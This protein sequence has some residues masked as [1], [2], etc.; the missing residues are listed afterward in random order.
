MGDS[1]PEAQDQNKQK[2]SEGTQILIKYIPEYSM[3]PIIKLQSVQTKDSP[4]IFVLP[5]IEGVLKLLAPLTT[6]LKANLWGL[7]Y[8]YKNP[9]DTIQDMVKRLLPLIEQKLTGKTFNFLAYSFG[10]TIALELASLLEQKGYTGIILAVDGS[11]YYTK[12]VTNHFVPEGSEA[13]NETMVLSTIFAT[14]L[15]LEELQKHKNDLVK[16]PSFDERFK[17]IISLI[18]KDVVD[19]QKL[20]KQAA[21]AVYKR[22]KAIRNYN[23]DQKKIKSFVKLYK[24]D[25]TLV[26]GLDEDYRMSEMC[27]GKVEVMSVKGDHHTMLEQKEIA[28]DINAIFKM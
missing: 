4:T 28:D 7:E 21:F 14:L 20:D 16:C 19:V 27:G 15:P 22:F 12:Q 26:S 6:K 11:P 17:L 13:E 1:K 8:S 3:E 23:I 25:V 24:A 5:G 9:E 18:P 10:S 2:I